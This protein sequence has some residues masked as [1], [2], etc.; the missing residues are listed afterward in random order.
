MGTKRSA[1]PLVL[2]DA[3]GIV[4]VVCYRKAIA[5]R[6]FGEVGGRERRKGNQSNLVSVV[7][8]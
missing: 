3:Y 8:Y 7:H 1:T 5:H 4:E 2:D 6:A